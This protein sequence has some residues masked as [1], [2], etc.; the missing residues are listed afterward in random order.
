L[1]R[2]NIRLPVLTDWY[3]I[4]LCPISRTEE[5]KTIMNMVGI[6]KKLL[7]PHQTWV[8]LVAMVASTQMVGLSQQLGNSSFVVSGTANVIQT[9]AQAYWTPLRLLRAK[10]KNLQPSTGGNVLSVT[11]QADNV[12]P[13]R[14]AGALPTLRPSA[15]DVKTLIPEFDLQGQ[16]NAQDVGAS[17]F[18]DN[19]NAPSMTSST[20]AYFTTYRVFPDAA[21][22]AYPNSTVG[23]LYF[24]DP[25]TGDDFV[26]S[27][28]TL[29]PRLVVTAGHCV[30]SPSTNASSRYFYTNLMF[31]PA[32]SNGVAPLGTWTPR[33]VWVTNTWYYSD[34]SVPNAQ[35]VGMLV[36]NDNN[37][38]KIGS[39]TGY[40]GYYT[41]QLGKNHAT[42]LG[43][44]GNLDSGQRMQVNHAYTFGSGGENTFQYG[45]AMRN[46]S[47]GGPWIQDY[48]VNP[49]SNPA[50]SGLGSNYL[51]SV[52]SYGPRATEP[53]YQGGSNLDSRFMNLLENACG[54]SSTG[55]CQ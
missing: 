41:G 38:S 25:K 50:V 51:I 42:M 53:K 8:T 27:A 2:K 29:R 35:D 12:P 15:H 55:N 40:L 9:E 22:S 36:M 47:S 32:F 33:T 28:S 14:M 19:S 5:G 49:T 26:C 39:V 21:V 46:G 4:I 6:E 11:T 54:A 44:P 13:V 24:H 18:V 52:T 17:A 20:N 16:V 23:K 30:A 31:V 34:G 37:G 45:S 1:G 3:R 10:S 7:F 48:G 43:Y